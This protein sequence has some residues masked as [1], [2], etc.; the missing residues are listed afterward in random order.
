GKLSDISYQ[1]VERGLAK[2][3]GN[4]LKVES[5]TAESFMTYLA[6]LIGQKTGF[7]PSTDRYSGLSK[8]LIPEGKVDKLSIKNRI[9]D[10]FRA[11]ILER[12]MPVP[13]YVG[14]I[15]DILR[16]KH[17]YY[18]ELKRFRG[19]IES[20][21]ID[22][23]I[24]NDEE[25]REVRVNRFLEEAKEEIEYLKEKMSFFGGVN[26]DFVTLCSLSS[27]IYPIASGIQDDNI[28]EVMGAAPGLLGAIYSTI[29][30]S[31]IGELR[32]KP[33]AYAAILSSNNRLLGKNNYI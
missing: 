4:W 20:F 32:R 8:L 17:K 24:I 28:I 2:K 26:I 1:L 9:S 3:E 10:E 18:N 30:S 31:N 29:F 11:E 15:S 7:V 14:D 25:L 12:I 21:L 22:I 23:E 13:R 19:F 5:Y 6:I 33:L 27:I 16:F